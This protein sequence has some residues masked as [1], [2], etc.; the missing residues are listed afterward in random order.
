MKIDAHCDPVA[1]FVVNI[2]PQQ[3]FMVREGEETTVCASF[4]GILIDRDVPISFILQPLSATGK[5]DV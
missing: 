5:G 3:F 4:G 1:V 2:S